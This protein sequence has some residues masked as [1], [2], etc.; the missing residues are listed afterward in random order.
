[1]QYERFRFNAT[2]DFIVAVAVSLDHADPHGSHA[3]IIYKNEN[4]TYST[5]H[6]CWY[7]RFSQRDLDE[8][9]GFAV[10]EIDERLADQV[11]GLCRLIRDNSPRIPFSFRFDLNARFCTRTGELLTLGDAQELTC[12]HFVVVVFQSAGIQL[13]DLDGWPLGRDADIRRQNELLDRLRRN[14]RPPPPAEFLERAESEIGRYPRVRAE[15]VAGA[16]LE[17]SVGEFVPVPYQCCEP[18]GQAVLRILCWL[19]K[20]HPWIRVR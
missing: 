11:A 2:G 17:E 8:D 10:P 14:T 3:A 1:M 9:F 16:C 18:N 6:Q 4:G 12:S 15:E 13:I 20:L 19:S 5:I 7:M